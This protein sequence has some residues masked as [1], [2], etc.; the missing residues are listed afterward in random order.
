MKR[1][2]FSLATASALAATAAATVSASFSPAVLA[3][4]PIKP[5]NGT[6]YLTL[7]KRAPVEA[8]T[9][10]IEVVEFFWYS[11]PHCNAFEP[12]LEAWI[13][14]APKDVVVRRA[15]V[16]FRDSFVPQQRLFYVLE[17]MGKIEELQR[18]VFF[19]I[20]V[21]KQTL[22]KEELIA[23]WLEKQGV[24]KAKFSELY[25][26]FAVNNKTRRATQLQEAYK[27]GGVPSL[28]IAGRFYTD[29]ESAKSMERALLITDY[30]V[31]EHRKKP[32]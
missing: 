13:K 17:A 7:E 22:D 6:D 19:A 1:R 21:E 24:D 4:N 20:H 15:P 9:G 25:N 28:G 11:C 2:D 27:V 3:Q 8:P 31:A 29:G 14:N 32:A 18:K 10:K 5:D 30:L 26:S 12:K 16:G 23:A